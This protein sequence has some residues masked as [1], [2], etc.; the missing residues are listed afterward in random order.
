[1]IYYMLFLIKN[2]NDL[3]NKLYKHF[4]YHFYI[5]NNHLFFNFSNKNHFIYNI[6]FN[7][8]Y[9]LLYLYIINNLILF[10]KNIIHFINNNHH[11]ISYMLSLWMKR[12]FFHVLYNYLLLKNILKNLLMNNNLVNISHIFNHYFYK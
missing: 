8:Y 4:K 7:I 1:M 11:Y 12:I 3:I 2:Y 9:I 5:L 10:L 6:N